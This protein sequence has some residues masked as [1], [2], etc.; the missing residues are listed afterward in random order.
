MRTSRSRSAGLAAE[1]RAWASA[2]DPFAQLKARARRSTGLIGDRD[3]SKRDY[4]QRR[5]TEAVHRGKGPTTPTRGCLPIACAVLLLA[6]CSPQDQRDRSVAQEPLFRLLP[7]SRTG[8]VFRNT[9][10]EQPTPQR[11]ELLFEYFANGGGVAV[12]DLNGDGLED[13]Y[14][15]GNMTYNSL[16]LNRGNLRFEDVTR[17]A[18]VAG[19]PN[20]WKTGVTFADVNGDGWLDIYVCYSGDLPLERRIDELYINLGNDENGIPHFAERA[21]QYGLASPHSS[22]QAY[23][24]DYDRD[25]DL[26]LFL[27]THNVKTTSYLDVQGTRREMK[28]ED[29]VNGVRLYR[30]DGD[31]FTD[32]T[33][34]VGISSSSLTY[35]L[36]A[37][38]SDVDK[39][40]WIDIYVG[41][42]YSPPDYLYMNNGDGT[43]SDELGSRIGHTSNASMGVDVADINNDGWPD[44]MVVDMLAEDNRRQKTLFIP[45]DRSV[46]DRFVQSGFHHQYMR[47]MLQLNNGDGTFSEIG[48][49][50]GVSNTDWSWAPLIADYDNDGRKD[51]FVTNGTLHDATDLD[52]LAFK[53]NYVAMKRQR[54]D[55]GDIAVLMEKLPTSDVANYVF[56]NEGNL[57]FRNV[58][59]E[60]GLGVPLKSMGATYSDLDNDGDLDLVTNNINDY[61]SLFENRSAH[62]P[63]NNYLQIKLE[64]RGKN[65]FGIGAKVTVYAGGEQQYAEQMPTRGYLSTVSP[66][67]HFGLGKL[68]AVDSVHVIWPD[69][70]AETLIHVEANRRITVHQENDASPAVFKEVP[71]P[72]K[73]EH[74][75][76]GEIDDFRRQPLMDHPRSFVGPPLVKADVNGDGL[77]DVF[78]G[79]GNEQAGRL[80][81]QQRD[82]RFV[83]VAQPALEADKRS[84]DVKAVFLDY[85]R[86][87]FLDLY[88]A[89][90]GYGSFR[91]DDAALQDRLYVNDGAGHFTRAEDALPPM[92]TSTGAVAVSDIN[93]D[94][95]P[96]LFVGGYVVPG[97][98]PEPPRSYVLLNDGRGHFEDRT[99]EVAPDLEHIGMVTDA[100]WHD[101]NG[102]GTEELIVVGAWMP[103]RIFENSGGRLRDVTEHYFDRPYAGSW[104]TVLVEDLNHDGIADLIAGNLGLN[105]QIKAGA[106]EPAELDYADFDDNGSV[107]PILSFFIQGTSYPYV[108]LDELRQQLPTI[109]SRFPSYHAYAEAKT[110][111]LLTAANRKKAQKLEAT[112]LETSLFMGTKAGRFERRALPIEAQFAPVFTITTLDYDRDGHTD[113]LLAGNI[114]EARIR[115]GKYDANY[116]VL[117]RGLP[118]GSFAYVPQYESGLSVRGDVRSVLQIGNKLLFGINRG[119]VQSFEL[120]GR[121]PSR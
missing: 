9:L 117:L 47:N 100:V 79:G 34:H 120:R 83:A 81:L 104:N 107:D 2:K 23:F 76:A 65:T 114:N 101:L 37:G 72:I 41:N 57:R 56:R 97:R 70:S 28:K 118:N 102:D 85:N 86:D 105:S 45:N 17:A 73:F 33:R 92:H 51:L 8:I 94:G 36:G 66:I 29:P 20:S 84:Q 58:S 15:T 103:I 38:I 93:G 48:Q 1:S 71:S 24:F 18:G 64:G 59:A 95:W 111:D 98:Y 89:S 21:R 32:V 16:Y 49:L 112:L 110:Q 25:G 14:F 40:G 68:A 52:F 7:P 115:L 91:S 53:R 77:V 46:F 19:R 90:G 44:I 121:G 87:G 74:R 113:L 78:A 80:Y 13:L 26:D 109:A 54:L 116:G 4:D 106:N 35:G 27:L 42:D 82:G 63:G 3:Y 31:H 61:A 50:A 62:A 30:N 12:G 22:N 67:L 119:V 5:I 55:P 88:V 75:M 108:T 69:G 6:S 96:D 11:T 43:F 39:D 99:A 10:S 60:W